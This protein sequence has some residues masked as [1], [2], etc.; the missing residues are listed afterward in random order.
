VARPRTL[1]R[2]LSRAGICSRTVARRLIAA[3]RVQVGGRV[4]RRSEAW[5]DAEA[6]AVLL[7]GRPI[8]SARRL[9][10]C[11]NK[12]KGYLTSF[13]D[14]RG[15]RTIY[16]LLSGVP[17]WVFPV[18]RLDRDSSGL[19]LLTNDS[20]F[21][22]RIASPRSGVTKLYRVETAGRI[23]AEQIQALR[24]EV[25]LDDGPARA[26]R[27]ALVGHRGGSSLVEI[28]L[29]EGRNRQVRRMVRAVGG[30]VR[31]LR[32]VAIGPVE[33][34]NLPSGELRPLTREELRRLR[35]GAPSADA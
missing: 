29:D 12:P 21:A 1:D 8:R 34:G 11:L 30:R 16:D 4:C 10:L 13:G 19:L 20:D 18:G 3:G 22:E 35:D 17:A 32:R 6:D 5:V 26:S 15:R 2:L 23:S 27:V 24:S 25:E 31:E 28:A 14:P 9:Y 33:L 7:D